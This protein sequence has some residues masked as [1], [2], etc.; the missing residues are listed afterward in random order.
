MATGTQ[1]RGRLAAKDSASRKP[2]AAAREAE[3]LALAVGVFSHPLRIR[4]METVGEWGEASPSQLAAEFGVN[5]TALSYHVRELVNAGL[6][7]RTRTR[8]R[9]GAIEHFYAVRA[10]AEPTLRALEVRSAALRGRMGG[11][12]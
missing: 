4:I 12:S 11:R 7:R 3:R 8:P 1:V 10:E 6:L 9:R 5:L 2:G